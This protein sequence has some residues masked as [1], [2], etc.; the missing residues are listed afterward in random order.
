MS[1]QE[2]MSGFKRSLLDISR[3]ATGPSDTEFHGVLRTDIDL[4]GLQ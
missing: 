2:V 4:T 1:K 3:M